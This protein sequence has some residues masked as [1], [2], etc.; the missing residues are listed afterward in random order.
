VK[1][2]AISIS[3]RGGPQGCQMLRI[4]HCLGNQLTDGGEV[5]SFMHRPRSLPQ[6]HF[7]LFPSL[8]LISV[9]G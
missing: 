2:K 1:H 7:F 6:K 9:R 5:A 8:L 3:G 4:T